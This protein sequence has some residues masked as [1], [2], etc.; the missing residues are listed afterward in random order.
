MCQVLNKLV[1]KKFTGKH[2]ISYLRK[3]SYCAHRSRCTAKRRWE[4]GVLLTNP[5]LRLTICSFFPLEQ[6]PSM[7]VHKK[8]KKNFFPGFPAHSSSLKTKFQKLVCE[9][10]GE[11]IPLSCR[12]RQNSSTPLPSFPKLRSSS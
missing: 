2:G 1:V 7:A 3:D 4:T 9:Y 5:T 12:L 6:K 11:K 8:K 10:W